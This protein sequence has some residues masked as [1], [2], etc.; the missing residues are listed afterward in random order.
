MS[1]AKSQRNTLAAGNPKI[2]L[3]AGDAEPRESLAL[4]VGQKPDSALDRDATLDTT[5][6][7]FCRDFNALNEEFAQRKNDSMLRL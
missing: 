3:I 1:S 4:L 7:E 5:K 6:Y 2:G